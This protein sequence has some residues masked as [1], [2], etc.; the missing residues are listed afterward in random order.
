MKNIGR[1]SVKRLA[2]E[3]AADWKPQIE[4]A[5]HR[6]LLADEIAELV[7]AVLAR[8]T[9]SEDRRAA[10]ASSPTEIVVPR[11]GWVVARKGDDWLRSAEF[12]ATER[13]LRVFLDEEVAKREARNC[14]PTG[15]YEAVPV[16]M[17][18][19]TQ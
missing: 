1:K 17:T 16:D 14:Y 11:R 19:R 5:H 2:E 13:Q 4:Q 12:G 15:F 9:A 10:L 18:R 3:L 8:Q 7:F 6:R